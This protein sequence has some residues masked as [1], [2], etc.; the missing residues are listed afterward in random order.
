MPRTDCAACSA[1]T[2]S[3]VSA[4]CALL[5]GAVALHAR[6][7][8]GQAAGIHGAL[9]QVVERDL[10]HQLRPH[11]H[12]VG[13]AAGLAREQLA[14]LPGEHLVGH[15]LEGLAEHDPAAGRVARAEVQ[16]RQPSLAAAAAPLGGEHDEVERVRALDLEPA[17]AA[18]AR[19]VGGVERLRHDA[20]VAARQRI[21]IEGLR[22]A[23]VRRDQA[24]DDERR[25]HRVGERVEALV[26][27]PVHERH[28][29]A[30]QAIEEEHRER[31][32]GAHARDVELAAEA[33]HRHLERLR[34]TA[35]GE[36]DR[37]A[38]EDQ[39]ARRQ[40]AHRLDD[41]GHRGR[42]VVQGARVDPDLVAGLVHLHAGAVDLPFEGG[43]AEQRERRGDVVGRLREHRLQRAEQ[44]DREARRGPPRLRSAR[45]GPR[46]GKLPTTIAAR[47]TSATG[48]VA[49]AAIAS[50]ITPSSAPWRNSPTSRR[51]RN[52]CSAAVARAN[53]ACSSALRSTAEP[54]PVV[55]AMRPSVAS[56]SRKASS[57]CGAGAPRSAASVR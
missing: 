13:V 27:R 24:R 16:V 51:T 26:R 35:R 42:H 33:A 14:R 17:R 4:S 52:S 40:V 10:D 5:V 53:S 3:I 6:E 43:G 8:Q 36:R 55:A 25:R 47:R 7:A 18:A 1:R 46:R 30:V 41:L 57:G 29:V 34:R 37:F 48:S 22:R 56:T 19:L 28:A 11:V 9:L 31:Q 45:P 50:I 54:F 20:F 32:L 23:D 49:A 12:G 2:V 39:L 44:R 15:A 38:V 21:G